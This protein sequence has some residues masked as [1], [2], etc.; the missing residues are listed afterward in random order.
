MARL[1]SGCRQ[2][3]RGT[4][5]II[6]ITTT[7]GIAITTG[8]ITAIT[9]VLIGIIIAIIITG[10]I[11]GVVTIGIITTIGV[12]TIGI[13]TITI[14]VTIIIDGIASR[15]MMGYDAFPSLR[16]RSNAARVLPSCTKKR[17]T[18]FT[19]ITASWQETELRLY[20]NVRRLPWVNFIVRVKL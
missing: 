13:I 10:I 15:W 7:T 12:T 16:N 5:I 6:V 9:I 19:G 1:A 11:T 14:T 4:I 8:I 2:L 18:G 3:K 20:S 17:S